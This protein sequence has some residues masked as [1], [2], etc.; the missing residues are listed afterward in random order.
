[1]RHSTWLPFKTIWFE[2]LE[3]SNN[4]GHVYFI[5]LHYLMKSFT[6]KVIVIQ[7]PKEIPPLKKPISFEELKRMTIKHAKETKSEVFLSTSWFQVASNFLYQTSSYNPSFAT[8]I[9]VLYKYLHNRRKSLC[10]ITGILPGFVD[11]EISAIQSA[12]TCAENTGSVDNI[13]E[14]QWQRPVQDY[15]G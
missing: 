15:R 1:M 7:K 14:V 11:A 12:A 5:Q 10:A 3:N 4:L 13:P 2:K 8:A 9:L 6:D